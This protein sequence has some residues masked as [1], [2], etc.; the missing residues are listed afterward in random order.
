M[1]NAVVGLKSFVVAREALEKTALSAAQIRGNL[2]ANDR[3][4]VHH[5]RPHE[6]NLAIKN[7]V[8]MWL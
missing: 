2:K 6:F 4:A 8:K 1:M 3:C 5:S 7:L